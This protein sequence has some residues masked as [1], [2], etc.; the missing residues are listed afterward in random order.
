MSPSAQRISGIRPPASI[1]PGQSQVTI[2]VIAPIGKPKIAEFEYLS[3][4]TYIPPSAQ[5]PTLAPGLPTPDLPT[6]PTPN[7]DLRRT[8]PNKVT[9][10]FTNAVANIG[11]P[12]ADAGALTDWQSG[13]AVA[14]GKGISV[15]GVAG[16]PG[17][18]RLVQIALNQIDKPYV[19]GSQGPESFDCSGLMRWSYG[20]IGLR[21]PQGTGRSSGRGQWYDMKPVD[22][23]NVKPGDLVFFDLGG[24]GY[25]DHVAMLVGDINSDGKWDIVHA[26]NPKLGVRTDYSVFESSYYSSKIL[27]FRTAR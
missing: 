2:P 26:A 19:W 18:D 10:Q 21:I 3:D 7:D 11:P 17:A 23:T 22:Q 27:G 15:Q 12:C 8:Q 4:P 5:A 14:W 20:Q 25:V 24:S 6:T 13:T 9:V 1:P 16:P